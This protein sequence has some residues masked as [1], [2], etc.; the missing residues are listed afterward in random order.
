MVNLALAASV[1]SERCIF[2]SNDSA[3]IRKL[4][5][6]RMICGCGLTLFSATFDLKVS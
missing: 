3:K 2:L 5:G 6:I 1:Y 4:F